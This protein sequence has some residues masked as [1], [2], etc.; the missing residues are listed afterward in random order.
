MHRKRR[1]GSG[2]FHANATAE[3]EIKP[4]RISAKL[5]QALGIGERELPEWIY[6]M[7]NLGFIEGYPPAYRKRS[8][9]LLF[10]LLY[11]IYDTK[12]TF[13]GQRN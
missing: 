4:G 7:R 9:T 12:I 13:L 1:E 11:H 5:R 2:R 6:R 3:E 10:A 8:C